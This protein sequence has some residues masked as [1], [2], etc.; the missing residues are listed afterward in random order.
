MKTKRLSAL[1]ILLLLFGVKASCIF[2]EEVVNM[3]YIGCK[4]IKC[5]H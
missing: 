5:N 3:Q 4:L 1:L 2:A